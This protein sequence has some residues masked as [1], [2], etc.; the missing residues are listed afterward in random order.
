MRGLRVQ[1]FP[2][3]AMIVTAIDRS[4]VGGARNARLAGHTGNRRDFPMFATD[5]GG[6][7]NAWHQIN[8]TNFVDPHIH[9]WLIRPQ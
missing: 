2:E 6:H 5:S 1:G 9:M 3:H 8:N 7:A 4:R